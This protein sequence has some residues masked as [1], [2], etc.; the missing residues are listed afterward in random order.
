MQSLARRAVTVFSS[1]R[2]VPAKLILDFPT[3]A[4]TL[5]LDVEF[6]RLFMYP[7]WL[8]LFPLVDISMC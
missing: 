5:P 3:M 8:P 2:L 1:Q 4:L 7:V 6:F